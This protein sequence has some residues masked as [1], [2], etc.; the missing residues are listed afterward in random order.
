MSSSATGRPISAHCSASGRPVRSRCRSM[1]R[2]RHRRSSAC[3][4]SRAR[5]FLSTATRLDVIAQA[6]PPDRA[7]LRD[8]ALVIFTSGSTGEPKGVVIGHR[9]LA[10]KLAVLDPLLKIGSDDVV[11]LPLH[12]TFIFG[13]WVSLLTLSKGARLVLVPKFSSEAM[14]L[15]LGEATVLGRRP[16]DVS[17][18]AELSGSGGAEAARDPDRRRGAATDSW[19]A[20]LLQFAAV[21]DSRSLWPDRN[22]LVRFLPRTGRSA[23]RARH[24][25]AS[26]RWRRVPAATRRPHRRAGRNRRTANPHAVWHVR[27][28]RRSAADRR[29]VRRRLFQHRRSRAADRRRLLSN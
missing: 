27:L 9:R 1:W 29:F 25:R 24:D 26:D 2:P 20:R 5:D 22:R 28:S 14:T 12:L 18:F 21:D 7:L 10:D 11:L 19:R 23:A 17:H 6:P 16:V 15:G 3:A 4:A 8:A 13:L